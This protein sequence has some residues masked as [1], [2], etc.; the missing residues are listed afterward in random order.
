MLLQRLRTRRHD[1]SFYRHL[2]VPHQDGSRACQSPRVRIGSFLGWPLQGTCGS[3]KRQH[4]ELQAIVYS[5]SSQMNPAAS[6]QNQAPPDWQPGLQLLD[7]YEIVKVLGEGGM[8]K[9]YLVRSLSSGSQFAVKRAKGMREADRKAFLAE[10]QTW[11]DLPDHPNLVPC[12][13]FRT[14]G[15]EVLIFAEYVEGGSLK[16]WIDSRRLYEGGPDQALERMLD[17]AIQLAWGLHCV[18]ELGT[19]HQDVKPGNVLMGRDGKTGVQGVKPQVTDFGLA[20]ARAAAGESFVSDMF[21]STLVSSGGGTPAYWSPEQSMGQALTHKTDIWSWGLSVLELFTGE[22]T[23]MSGRGAAEVLE[24]YLEEDGDDGIPRMPA[25]LAD[26]LRQCFQQE[27]L[28]R[29]VSLA[30]AVEQ[31]QQIYR[32]SV[33]VRYSRKLDLIERDVLSTPGIKERRHTESTAWLDPQVWLEMALRAA[34]RDPSEAEAM[35]ARRGVTRRGELVAEL[36]VYDEAKRLYER[37][38]RDGLK[39]LEVDLATLCMNK[40]MVHSTAADENGA[41]Q[42]YDQAISILERLFYKEDRSKV[43]GDLAVAYMNKAIS[44]SALGDKRE[45]VALYDQAIALQERLLNHESRRQ[46]TDSLAATYMNKATALSD[47]ADRRGAVALCDQAI[48]IWERLVNEEGR[49]E[50]ANALALAY[51]N[52]AA[53]MSDLGDRRGAIVLYDQALVI[54]ERQVNLENCREM[55]DSLALVYMNKAVAMS[56]LGDTRGAVT[57]FDQAIANWECLVNHEGRRELADRLASAYMNKS[58]ALFALGDN[59]GSLSII[60]QAIAIWEH[61]VNREGRREL[62]DDLAMAYMNKAHTLRQLGDNIGVVALY[63]KTIMIREWLVNHEG[64]RELA[65]RLASAYMKKATA[66]IT[67]GDSHGAVALYN[68]AIE[69]WERVVHQEGR[70]DLADSLAEA[71]LSKSIVIKHQGDK[72]GAIQLCD[73]AITIRECLTDQNGRPD[74]NGALARTKVFRGEI[75]IELRER[76]KGLEDLRSAQCILETEIARTGRSGLERILIRVQHQLEELLKHKSIPGIS[77][78][79]RKRRT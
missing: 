11:I 40:A 61:M 29:P 39:E 21:R 33:G 36:I 55:A 23:W 25:S 57:I 37:L 10:L 2:L 49:H 38:V 69:L 60:D 71:Y 43:A 63:D 15:T 67:S 8:G 28:D 26:L 41:R 13:F 31:L 17:V 59:N 74:L 56:D 3:S 64:R 51:M 52:K 20:R 58:L 18:H 79:S 14:V 48:A 24:Q 68:Q 76:A 7:D 4:T 30:E 72:R 45:A 78:W 47:L 27:P 42:E 12:R 50:L 54:R 62:A 53:A 35:V 19:V 32:Q 6:S 46:L 75:L 66:M 44:A 34:G 9:V 73:K 22:V 1:I 65:D 16:D 77:L 70:S 5:K